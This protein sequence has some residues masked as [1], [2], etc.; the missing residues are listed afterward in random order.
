M[1]KYQREYTWRTWQLELLSD[2]ED[3]AQTLGP[4]D[5]IIF[6]VVDGQQRLMVIRP[7]SETLASQSRRGILERLQSHSFFS[8]LPGGVFQTIDAG[9]VRT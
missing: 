9:K 8:Q 2:I 5:E 6:E 4:N 7:F 3:D 1:P